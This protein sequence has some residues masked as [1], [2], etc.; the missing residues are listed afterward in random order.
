MGK[1]PTFV[2]LI[3]LVLVLVLVPVSS[4]QWRYYASS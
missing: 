2:V 1:G 3:M 4:P